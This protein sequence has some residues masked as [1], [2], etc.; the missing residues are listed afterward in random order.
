MYVCVCVCVCLCAIMC[1]F[2]CMG[3]TRYCKISKNLLFFSVRFQRI[4]HPETKTVK[5]GPLSFCFPLS[6]VCVCVC[7]CVFK[8]ICVSVCT[9]MRVFVCVC[10]CVCVWVSEFFLRLRLLLKIWPSVSFLL[11]PLSLR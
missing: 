1:G 8:C 4:P 6:Y 10:V 3:V 7:M 5:N 2:K 11:K 9:R